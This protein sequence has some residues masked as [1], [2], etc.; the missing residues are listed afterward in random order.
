MRRLI[1]LLLTMTL[2]VGG[3]IPAW[4]ATGMPVMLDGQQVAVVED[5]ATEGIALDQFAKAVGA[6]YKWDAARQ[7]ATVVLGHRSFVMWADSPKAVLNGAVRTLATAPSLSGNTLV[8]PARVV[9]EALGL[10]V[11]GEKDGALILRSGMGLI[12]STKAPDFTSDQMMKARM[13]MGMSVA[14]PIDPQESESFGLSMEQ[15]FH[16]YQDDLMIKIHMSMFNQEP[17]D[18]EMA[19]VGGKTYVKE[20]GKGWTATDEAEPPLEMVSAQIGQV[21]EQSLRQD[22]PELEGAVVTVTGTS[23]MDGAKV[24]NVMVSLSESAIMPALSL[25][26]GLDEAV[27]DEGVKI[28]VRRYVQTYAINPETGVVH[29][30]HTELLVVASDRTG[31]SM[32]MKVLGDLR[33]SPVSV[34]LALPAD[35]P[36]K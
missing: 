15:E 35:F 32:E 24:V 25:I 5:A 10:Y 18:V 6:E 19:Y 17:M 9:A 1:V 31:V 20:P 3:A 26:M 11:A 33:V 7:E 14:N 4:A 21:W 34:P 13:L 36:A 30:S 2:L 27:Q 16:K 29:E 12:R 22:N 23:E 28:D 8:A